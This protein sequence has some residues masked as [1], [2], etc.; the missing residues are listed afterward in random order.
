MGVYKDQEMGIY[1]LLDR[2]SCIQ[3]M[4]SG[5]VEEHTLLC[6][7]CHEHE[8]TLLPATDLVYI[9]RR[10]EQA[11]S[12]LSELYQFFGQMYDKA[13]GESGLRVEV[14]EI[15]GLPLIPEDVEEITR[16]ETVGE[17]SVTTTWKFREPEDYYSTDS[18][19]DF[20][21][22]PRTQF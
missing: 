1:E 5:M 4:L 14:G 3:N 19:A 20:I 13:M 18:L 2:T 17:I 6:T 15:E 22:Q 8:E 12:S 7:G 11:Q 21:K 10:L 16:T 9:K